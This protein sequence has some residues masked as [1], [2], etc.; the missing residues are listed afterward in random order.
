MFLLCAACVAHLRATPT[1]PRTTP[2]FGPVFAP[3]LQP[4]VDNPV[5]AGAVMLVAD[6]DRILH[7]EA[8]GHADLASQRPM[9]VDTVFWIA[10]MTKPLTAAA[11]MMLVD[12]GLVSVDDPASRHLPEFA[13][14]QVRQPDGTLRPPATPVLIRHL[15]SHTSGI[16][17]TDTGVAAAIDALALADSVALD[18]RHPLAAEPGTTYFYTNTGLDAAALI[19]ERVTGRPFDQFLQER[20]L[21]PLGMTDTTFFPSRDQLSRLAETYKA[22]AGNT[23]LVE[24]PISHLTYPLDGP[25]RHVCPGGGL[26]STAHDLSRFCQMLLNGGTFEGKRYLSKESVRAMTTKQ[27]AATLPNHYGFGTSASPDGTEF[28]HGGAHNTFMT[29]DHGEIRIF[30]IHHAGDFPRDAHPGKRFEAEVRRLYPR[31]ITTPASPIEG[32]PSH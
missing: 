25:G 4:L 16:R 31:A 21:T 2:E 23:G 1:P 20:L 19:I 13:N 18:L 14:L 5:F 7:L 26:F 15:L 27:T 3:A 28:G 30:L 24:T 6:R 12:E 29:V 10:S 11:F 9:T 32:T 8:V 17:Y 22:N